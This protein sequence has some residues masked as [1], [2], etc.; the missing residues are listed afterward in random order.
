MKKG[1]IAVPVADLRKEPKELL[2][3]DFSHHSLRDSQ[4]LY[5]ERICILEEWNEWLRIEAV[6]QERYS[7]EKGWHSYPGW[8][9]RS[10]IVQIEEPPLPNCAICVPWATFDPLPFFLS[11]G[12]YLHQVEKGVFLLPTG[13]Q[14]TGDFQTVRPFSTTP[15]REILLQDAQ[16]FVGF[17]YLWGG[18]ASYGKNRISSVDCSGLVNL[19]YR[20][21]GMIIPRDAHDQFLKARKISPGELLPG[22][23]I[24]LSREGKP[25]RMTHVVL[26]SGAM[27]CLEAPET[28]K[29]VRS[30]SILSSLSENL[31][32]EERSHAYHA[33]YGTYFP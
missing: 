33:H 16:L 9:L 5:G 8:I 6:E 30:L 25:E 26:Y 22:D 24:Y 19:L 7:T 21:Q 32:L 27:T 20:G 13:A 14:A 17:P 10:E 23:L 28:G 1:V 4:L 3:Q 11:Y 18:R 15:S 2:P 29:K 31:Y 12:T